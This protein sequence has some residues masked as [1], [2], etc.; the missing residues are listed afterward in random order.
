M[1]I[2]TLKNKLNKVADE[3]GIKHKETIKLSQKL[4]KLIVNNMKMKN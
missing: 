1:N 2:S 4:D 3:K